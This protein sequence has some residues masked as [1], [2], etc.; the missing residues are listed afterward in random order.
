MPEFFDSNGPLRG[1]K[2]DL[3]EGGIRVPLIARW[4]GKIT[5]GTQSALIS[6][7]WDM[8][9]TFCELAGV[10]SPP[11]LDGI[12]LVPTLLS[13]GKQRQHAFLYWEF[14][15]QGGKQAVRLGRWKGVRLNLKKNPQSPIQLYDLSDDVGETTD[16][17]AAHPN[18]VANIRQAMQASHTESSVFRLF[19]AK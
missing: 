16:V 14:H 8:L 2:R 11:G 17:A 18:V 7:Q 6:A 9:P 10:D 13:Q 1:F 19:G 12:S 3:Y 5:P 4:P 15:E